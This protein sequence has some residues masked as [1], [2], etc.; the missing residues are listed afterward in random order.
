MPFCCFCK[1][2]IAI[3]SEVQDRKLKSDIIDSLNDVKCYEGLDVKMEF[4]FIV[5]IFVFYR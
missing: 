5:A 3:I 4:D 2:K 1:A